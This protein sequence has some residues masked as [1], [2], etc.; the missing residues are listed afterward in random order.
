MK[1]WRRRASHVGRLGAEAHA[2]A[3]GLVAGRDEV[4]ADRAHLGERE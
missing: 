1:A 4:G 2:L 3:A